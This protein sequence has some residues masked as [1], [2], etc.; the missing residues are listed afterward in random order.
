MGLSAW[1][2]AV[3]A[4]VAALADEMLYRAVALTFL[5]GWLRCVW[6]RRRAAPRASAAPQSAAGPPVRG[7]GD[8]AP[9]AN[10]P[11]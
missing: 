9:P 2:E 8:P 1:S 6:A 11:V 10:A 5:A 4:A 3:V 7:S